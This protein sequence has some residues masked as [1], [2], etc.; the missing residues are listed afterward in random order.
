[1]FAMLF[2]VLPLLFLSSA[3]GQET[4]FELPR[5]VELQVSS[6]KT[7]GVP[8]F[9]TWGLP[10]SDSEG[11]VYFHVATSSYRDSTLLAVSPERPDPIV[12]SLKDEFAKNTYFQAFNV[13]PS[14]TVYILTTDGDH[15]AIVFEFNHGGD[16]RSH[17]TLETPPAVIVE[18]F[19]AFEA[20]GNMVVWGYYGNRAAAGEKGKPFAAIMD[21]SG[22]LLRRLEGDKE[23]DFGTAGSKPAE[24]CAYLGADGNMYVLDSSEILVLTEAGTIQRRIPVRKPANAS[25]PTKLVVSDGLAAVWL[26][27]DSA[28]GTQIGLTLE[29]IDTST[30]KVVGIYLPSKDLGNNAVSFSRSSGFVFFQNTNGRLSELTAAIQ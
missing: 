1:M 7:V 11:F 17:T 4:R 28:P 21:R 23:R 18:S 10:Q 3:L 25:L 29:T 12:F 24:S 6:V 16:L 27:T 19:A 20:T 26:Q 8:F 5:A 9:N 2:A 15:H 14:G 30:G 22:K 13:T